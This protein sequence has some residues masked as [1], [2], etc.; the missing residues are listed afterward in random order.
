VVL[1]TAGALTAIST[2]ERDLELRTEIQARSH[3]VEGPEH[4]RQQIA[5]HLEDMRELDRGRGEVA[6]ILRR[7]GDDIES[8]L[9]TATACAFSAP[10]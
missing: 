2:H 10:I 6:P 8:L 4:K 7:Q 3:L 1:C 5:W 9:L